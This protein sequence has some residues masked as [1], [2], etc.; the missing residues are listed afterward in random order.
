MVK[1]SKMIVFKMSNHKIEPLDFIDT[2]EELMEYSTPNV[3]TP[4]LFRQITFLKE[5]SRPLWQ[6]DNQSY[7]F[8]SPIKTK[9]ELPKITFDIEHPECASNGVCSE[10]KLSRKIEAEYKSEKS[11]CA[12]Q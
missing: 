5:V 11:K 7:A 6:E 8:A 4:K 2:P 12:Q 3:Q 1:V 9:T 10:C